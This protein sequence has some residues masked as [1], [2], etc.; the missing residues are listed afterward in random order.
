MRLP[1]PSLRWR[2]MAVIAIGLLGSLMLAYASSHAKGRIESDTAAIFVIPKSTINSNVLT[3]QTESLIT[4]AGIVGRAVD[5]DT[6][7]A[8][9]RRKGMSGDYTLEMV[10]HGTQFASNF[11]QPTL[12]VTV[13]DSSTDRTRLDTRLLLAR[14]RTELRVRQDAVGVPS[15]ARITMLAAPLT[16]QPVWVGGSP[17]RAAVGSLVLGTVL[18]MLG[19][20]LARRRRRRPASGRRPVVT[21]QLQGLPL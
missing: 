3:V 10:N 11:D 13:L 7:R 21:P 16:P 17:K 20:K 12:L 19:V 14:L 2:V 4:T 18:T 1:L 8:E 6:V 5:D 15:T 9:L